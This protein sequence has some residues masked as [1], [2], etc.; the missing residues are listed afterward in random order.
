VS[1]A[2]TSSPNNKK[3]VALKVLGRITNIQQHMLGFV[4]E[5]YVVNIYRIL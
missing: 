4:F 1:I 2:F 3:V 5:S